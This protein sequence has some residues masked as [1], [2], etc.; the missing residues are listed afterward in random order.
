[1]LMMPFSRSCY[2]FHTVSIRILSTHL[3]LCDLLGWVS[4]MLEYNERWG[5]QLVRLR[6]VESWLGWKI[7]RIEYG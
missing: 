1:M 7:V 3:L 4:V 6:M 2:R 5:E